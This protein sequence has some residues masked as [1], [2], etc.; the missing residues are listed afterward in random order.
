MTGGILMVAFPFLCALKP[1]LF[2]RLSIAALTVVVVLVLFT[3][4]RIEYPFTGNIR[5]ESDASEI[6]L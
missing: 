5:V 1:P 4:Y 6:V 2:H 3:I